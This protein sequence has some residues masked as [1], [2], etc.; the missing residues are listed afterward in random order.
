M[1]DAAGRPRRLL[2]HRLRGPSGVAV[3]STDG[4]DRVGLRA[5]DRAVVVAIRPALYGGQGDVEVLRGPGDGPAV[6]VDQPGQLR[7][8]FGSVRRSRGPSSGGAELLTSPSPHQEVLSCLQP[9]LRHAGDTDSINVPGQE[10]LEIGL[11]SCNP[12]YHSI[13]SF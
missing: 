5:Q 12:T 8:C 10:F 11:A 3:R 7:A 6:F 9:H 1:P 13:I 4:A 2:K